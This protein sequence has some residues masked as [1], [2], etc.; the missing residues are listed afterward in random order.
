MAQSMDNHEKQ[1]DEKD[2]SEDDS[3]SDILDVTPGRATSSQELAQN[4]STSKA[5]DSADADILIEDGPLKDDIAECPLCKKRF[6]YESDRDKQALNEHVDL[7]LNTSILDDLKT[8]SPMKR[9][10]PQTPRNSARSN[11][12]AKRSK[13]AKA[14]N[15]GSQETKTLNDYFGTPKPST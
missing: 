14:T 11:K 7:C 13:V 2:A 15:S 3:D 5:V 1:E 4:P 12:P 6:K 10:A 9:K 8:G